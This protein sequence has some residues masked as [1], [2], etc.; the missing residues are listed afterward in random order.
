MKKKL[1]LINMTD[2]GSTG[3]IMLQTADV[4]R[5]YGYEVQ[6]YS[7]VLFSKKGN[8]VKKNIPGHF[9]FGSRFSAFVHTY[10][11]MLFGLNGLFSFF[12]TKRLI[13]NLK[14][15]NPD[16]VHLHNLHRF[17]IN[18][19][20]FF[21][22]LK[23]S[24]VQVVW[25]L[26]DCWA[27]TG[28]CPHFDMIGCDKWKTG[29]YS[30]SQTG[31]YPK[32]CIDTSRLMFK[33]KKQWFG[34]LEKLTLVT[35]SQWLADLTKES[36]LRKF[37]IRVINNG[38]DLSVFRPTESDFRARY[39]LQNKFVLL[40]VAFGW[41]ERKGL[42]VFIELSKRLDDSFRIVLVGTNDAIDANL[43]DNIISIHR[44]EN[45]KEL[46][47]I[48][49]ASDLF[50]NPTREESYPTV[51]MEALACG[52]PVLTFKTGGSPEIPDALCGTAVSNHD[53]HM[54]E[55]EIIRIWKTNAFSKED[56]LKRARAFDK[57][58]KYMEYIKLYEELK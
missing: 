12:A 15:F 27:F 31:A 57:N 17:C 34:G 56:C 55:K 49:S 40:G 5:K 54:L 19:P 14:K 52:T 30:C 50:V 35:P 21:K 25:T 42:D 41:D 39:N 28:H 20:S 44:T 36:F 6:T 8:F 3:K 37:P 47:E 13:K 18:L 1:A 26:H 43:P 29:C 2:V 11:G 48:Y 23:K 45:Q 7:A 51:N 38:I 9:Y 32:S 24:N 10:C 22:Y 46:A 4:A 33:L 16:I 53:V 58:A